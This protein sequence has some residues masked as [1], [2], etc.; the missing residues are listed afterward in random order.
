MLLDAFF[1]ESGQA[2]IDLAPPPVRDAFLAADRDGAASIPPRSAAMFKVN[3]KDRAWVDAQCTPQ[4][5]RCGLQRLT[6]AGARERI[7]KKTYIRAAGYP[8]APFDR[9]REKA[10]AGGWRI[11]EVACGHDV[12]LD[13]PARLAEILQDELSRRD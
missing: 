5:I 6:L 7:A 3:D 11:E 1:P 8:S 12:M 4:P 2:L 9:A 10:R 13:A